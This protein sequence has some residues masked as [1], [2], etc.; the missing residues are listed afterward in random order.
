M[1]GQKSITV[2]GAEVGIEAILLGATTS[3]GGLLFGYDIGQ[4]SGILLFEDFK[5]RFAN[6]LNDGS[7]EWG[8]I[9]QSVLVS[10]MSIG[11]LLGA[12]SGAYTADWWG[13]RRSILF[14]VGVFI[15]GYIVQIT[16]MN[17]GT[18]M[19]M[20]RI[21]TGLGIGNLS[22]GVP[23][24]QSETSPPGIRGA[25]M[26][27]YQLM[28][29]MGIL[30]ASTVNY[31]VQSLGA[32]E[33]S[34]RVVIGIGI[35]MSLPLAFGIMCVPESPRWLASRGDW[36]GARMSLA[37]LRGKKHDPRNAVIEEDLGELR[38][39]LE[40]GGQ[41]SEGSWLECFS[42]S[43]NTPKVL[44]RTLLGFGIHFLQ[45]WSGINFFFYFGATI[46]GSA[47]VQDPLF[48]QNILGTVNVFMT[49]YGV[50][51]VEKFGRRWPLFIGAL[52]Q[53]GW[54]FVFAAVCTANP[55]HP[56]TGIIMIV[57]ACMFIASFAGTWGPMAWSVVGEIF[58]PRTRAKQ[59]SLATAGNWLG[60]FM[61][62]F[63]TPVAFRG[64]GCAFGF[65]FVVANLA[66][67]L[68]VYLCLYESRALSL[69]DVDLMYGQKELKAWNSSKWVPPGYV[70]G[71]QRAWQ[72][73]ASI[74]DG[75]G[76]EVEENA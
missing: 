61:I 14:G 19:M 22:V 27:S 68:L 4:I 60:N 53:A 71:R 50:F 52:W 65:V 8:P 35:L 41:V 38:Q 28:I 74:Q 57:C 32:R 43:T 55:P 59:A 31:G 47:G 21:V 24:Y 44:Y 56:K 51:V 7:F 46:F 13:R 76:R 25:V 64:I 49:L 63:L 30:S 29:A 75:N 36:E 69:E 15:V 58:P 34:W 23:L 45:Q 10:L 72:A 62:G 18:H 12:L 37:R 9:W 5:R 16:A 48:T 67:A 1:L 17:S 3:I 42:T 6:H 73:N 33:V 11:G 54:F 66:A 2:D 39:V 70:T 40:K 26:A 20:G